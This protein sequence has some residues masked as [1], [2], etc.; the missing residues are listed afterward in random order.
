MII[1][2]L[3]R[4]N[5]Q[6]IDR[7]KDWQEA[8]FAAVNPLVRTGYAEERYIK[9]IIENTFKYGPYYILMPNVALIHGRPDQ[10]VIEKQLAVTLLKEPVQFSEKSYPVKLLIALAATDSESHVG[11]MKEIA[12]ILMKEST[13]NYILESDS[14]AEVYRFFTESAAEAWEIDNKI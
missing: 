6:I 1:N 3:K 9:G 10:G 12:A 7:V 5:V 8:I 4:E 14:E 11:A 2:M 13:I